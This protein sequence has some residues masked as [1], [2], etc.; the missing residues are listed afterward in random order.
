MKGMIFRSFRKRNSSQKNTNTAYSQYPYSRIVP[1]ERALSV[2]ERYFWL[3]IVLRCGHCSV[4][5]Q[6]FVLR[7]LVVTLSTTPWKYHDV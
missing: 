1:K 4:S 2:V 7:H 3:A 6:T 5:F